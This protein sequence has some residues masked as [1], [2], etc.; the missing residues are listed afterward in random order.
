MNGGR[1]RT[2]EQVRKDARAAELY[3]QG[4]TFDQ[5]GQAFNPPVHKTTAFNMVQR[6]IRDAQA[7]AVR[8]PD[9]FTMILDR[10]QDHRR[11]LQDVIDHPCY[12]AGKDGQIVTMTDPDTGEKIPVIDKGPIVRAITEL[13]HHIELEAKL[14]DLFPASKSRV[15]VV[16]ED[17][18]DREIEK[19]AKELGQAAQNQAVPPEL[20]RG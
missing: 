19:L 12:L 6:A 13:R 18:V 8:G 10:I 14:L 4:L 5:V 11:K 2:I 7:R 3:R 15:E 9:A 20:P 17:V 1:R 16:T